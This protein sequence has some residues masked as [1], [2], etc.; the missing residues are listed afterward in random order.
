MGPLYRLGC[1][2]QVAQSH[3]E[4]SW[5]RQQKAKESAGAL[6]G[7]GTGPSVSLTLELLH[8]IRKPLAEIKEMQH[9]YLCPLYRAV[10]GTGLLFLSY[11]R[12]KIITFQ[13]FHLFEPNSH[14]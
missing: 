8:H 5:K 12:V 4:Q 10:S 11:L 7:A 9:I 3:H 2:N 13:K 6:V 14:G 1:Y